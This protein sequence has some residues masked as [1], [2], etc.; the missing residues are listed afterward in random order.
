MTEKLLYRPSQAQAA[1]GIRWTKFWALVKQ[2]KLEVR[3]SAGC[4]FVPADR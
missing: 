1:L 4:S 3:K 2:G